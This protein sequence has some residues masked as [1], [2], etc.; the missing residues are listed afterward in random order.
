MLTT[1]IDSDV[2]CITV[3]R[4]MDGFQ[5][6]VTNTSNIPPHGYRCY[7]DPHPGFPDITQTISCN[8]IGNYVI[9]FDNKGSDEGSSVPGAIIELCYVAINGMFIIIV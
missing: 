7:E 6:Y 2:I 4:H 3:A 8:Q 5:L 1:N 9:Y